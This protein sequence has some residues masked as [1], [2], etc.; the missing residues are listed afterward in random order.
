MHSP[1]LQT[2]R[3]EICRDTWFLDRN[4]GHS[5]LLI[6]RIG[7]DGK[8]LDPILVFKT[9]DWHKLKTQTI[10]DRKQAW[11]P[12]GITIKP[13]RDQPGHHHFMGWQYFGRSIRFVAIV[14]LESREYSKQIRI[15]TEEDRLYE[16][17]EPLLGL[18]ELLLAAD[19][20]SKKWC[21]CRAEHD[22]FST[23]MILCANKKCKLGWYHNI[24]M[25][26]DEDEEEDEWV[27]KQC[28]RLPTKELKIANHLR[29][30]Y[31][32]F[33]TASSSRIH[34]ARTFHRAWKKHHWPSSKQ[35]MKLFDTVRPN[36][37]GLSEKAN[38][39]TSKAPE[40]L[41][42]YSNWVVRETTKYDLILSMGSSRMQRK[43]SL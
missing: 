18:S 29:K 3:S 22:K 4:T 2:Y 32:D 33:E 23:S 6:V 34:R 27:C 9:K 25:G 17:L 35:I 38:L 8:I 1:S 13:E 43:W 16:P 30:P 5:D 21:R 36:V 24:C 12:Y 39:L 19:D 42:M 28:C 10:S 37:V 14:P 7:E 41:F 15:V 31:G 20:E 26:M 11:L 40:L